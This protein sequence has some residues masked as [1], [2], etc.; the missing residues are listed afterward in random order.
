MVK[1]VDTK[2]RGKRQK[3]NEPGTCHM[4]GHAYYSLSLT[5]LEIALK[6]Q[7]SVTYFHQEK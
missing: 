7:A 3:K 1:R 5:L 4:K 6:K 2:A